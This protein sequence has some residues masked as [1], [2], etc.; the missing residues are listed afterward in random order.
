MKR[1]IKDG[2]I[3][4]K[5]KLVIN[6]GAVVQYADFSNDGWVAEDIDD[7]L[8]RADSFNMG[9]KADV[10]NSNVY[11]KSIIIRGTKKLYIKINTTGQIYDPI[12]LGTENRHNRDLYKSGGKDF[13]EV[14][15]R[16]F[17]FYLQFLKT[18]NHAWYTNARREI[19]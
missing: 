2:K 14:T 4:C 18:K 19:I 11:A 13:V 1:L 7:P 8:V 5:V 3:W 15:P 12:G 10:D 6:G 16:V 17:G 9:I